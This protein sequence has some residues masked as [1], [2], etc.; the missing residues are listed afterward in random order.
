MVQC[1]F[2]VLEELTYFPNYGTNPNTGTPI[3]ENQLSEGTYVVSLTD[4]NGC[5]SSPLTFSVDI[6]ELQSNYC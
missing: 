1:F 6:F 2:K 3:N 4:N 5:L